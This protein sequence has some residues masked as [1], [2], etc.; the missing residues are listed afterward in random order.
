MPSQQKAASVARQQV[1]LVNNTLDSLSGRSQK[2]N[3]D[4]LE[5]KCPQS[6]VVSFVWYDFVLFGC[7]RHM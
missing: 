6:I 4:G 5:L 1:R 2:Y 7:L 3:R